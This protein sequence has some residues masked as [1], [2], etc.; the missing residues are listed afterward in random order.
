MIHSI[1]RTDCKHISLAWQSTVTLIWYQP[2]AEHGKPLENIVTAY[3]FG[4]LCDTS[5][6]WKLWIS[7]WMCYTGHN[8][9]IHLGMWLLSWCRRKGTQA[10]SERCKNGKQIGMWQTKGKG[11]VLKECTWYN[12]VKKIDA[13]DHLEQRPRPLNNKMSQLKEGMIETSLCLQMSIHKN[14]AILNS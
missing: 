5:W 7:H 14:K 8:Q 12:Y 2:F 3:C 4:V 1:K 10:D 9:W 11:W 13:Y 6:A